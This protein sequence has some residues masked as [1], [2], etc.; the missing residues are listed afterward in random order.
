MFF[1]WMTSIC[2]PRACFLFAPMTSS[3]VTLTS[4]QSARVLSNCYNNWRKKP[5]FQILTTETE[6]TT[7]AH[8]WCMNNNVPSVGNRC[9]WITWFW[10]ERCAVTPFS[11]IVVKSLRSDSAVWAL[12]PLTS[13]CSGTE[14]QQC[15]GEFKSLS[16]ALTLDP[17]D[18]LNC[19]LS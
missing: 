14:L 15:G 16:L 2:L 12:L 3:Y 5:T 19:H 10:R 13:G 7:V 1:T 9:E 17:L 6:T 8:Q 18:L 11:W 4:S